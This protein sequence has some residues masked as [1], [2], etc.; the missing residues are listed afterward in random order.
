MRA[1]GG[2]NEAL[3]SL[4]PTPDTLSRA[5]ER[6]GQV[7][8]N[9]LR[10]ADLGDVGALSGLLQSATTREGTPESSGLRA[11]LASPLG[12]PAVAV[13]P[14]EAGA[15]G[16]LVDSLAQAANNRLRAVEEAK[17]E[18]R[19]GAES[20]LTGGGAELHD[21]ILAA[22]KAGIELRLTMQLRNKLIE[23]YQE[24]MRLPV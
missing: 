17:A 1:I 2:V 5:G 21:V 12:A 18:V 4:L 15:V 3:G 6:F 7:L 9:T 14:G 11:R 22:E 8:D 23:A 13:R 16:S 10:Q 19:T 20:L 24:V